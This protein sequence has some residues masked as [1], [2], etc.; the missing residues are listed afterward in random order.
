MKANFIAILGP[1]GSGKTTIASQLCQRSESLGFT[2][3]LH[4]SSNFE[5]LPTFSQIREFLSGKRGGRPRYVEGFKGFHSGM[6]QKPN[7]LL[8]SLV[9]MLWYAIDLNLGR[10]RVKKARKSNQLICFARYYYDYYFQI[11]NSRTPFILI[12]L[13]E[14]TI[15][16]P[17]LVFVLQRSAQDIYRSKPELTI[18]EIE[19]Q[20][21][22]IRQLVGARSNFVEIDA[23]LGIDPTL[24]R[25]LDYLK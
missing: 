20:Q 16:K 17:D 24:T 2:S 8:I 22:I 3:A 7:S 13:V 1:D 23:S 18:S 5:I 19:R 12:R 9:L 15:P 14:L 11:A 6:S 25:I 10:S 4:L 21:N